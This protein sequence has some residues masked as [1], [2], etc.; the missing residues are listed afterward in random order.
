M[1]A[2]PIRS[3]VPLN[4]STRMELARQ[5]EARLKELPNELAEKVLDLSPERLLALQQ[6]YQLERDHIQ[7][8]QEFLER[9]GD[10]H[11]LGRE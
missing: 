8:A 9:Y 1:K 10:Q 4:P 3:T 5:L 2:L 7:Y 6:V 11:V